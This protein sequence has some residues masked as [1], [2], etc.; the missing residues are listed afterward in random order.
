MCRQQHVDK[1]VYDECQHFNTKM[2]A[3]RR[4]DGA[5]AEAGGE[6]GLGGANGVQL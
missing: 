4:K 3:T 6:V 1:S 5:A 2:R